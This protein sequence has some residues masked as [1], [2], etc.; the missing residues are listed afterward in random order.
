[1]PE[2][3]VQYPEGCCWIG[4][5][6]REIIRSLSLH[7][8][9]LQTCASS[10]VGTCLRRGGNLKKR[11]QDLIL[12]LASLSPILSPLS[13]QFCLLMQLGRVAMLLSVA[14]ALA[15][16]SLIEH[17]APH[18]HPFYDNRTL[19]CKTLFTT[20]H[21]IGLLYISLCDF[22]YF[23]RVQFIPSWSLCRLQKLNMIIIIKLSI[24]QLGNQSHDVDLPTYLKWC[25]RD[26][27]RPDLREMFCTA[28]VEIINLAVHILR[29]ICVGSLA[30]PGTSCLI[31]QKNCTKQH[32][33][34]F[35]ACS[36]VS[37]TM[38][39]LVEYYISWTI[40]CHNHF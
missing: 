38:K 12:T 9:S 21:K 30:S 18:W 16:W 26:L 14:A 23:S 11:R 36:N 37:I 27:W 7:S 8:G 29:K 22:L 19:F 17:C 5:F 25:H 34:L 6:Q 40:N 15:K 10:L 13:T 39:I 28:F 20:V 35:I 24:M 4:R 33:Y 32:C 2:R 31:C 3:N 1:M